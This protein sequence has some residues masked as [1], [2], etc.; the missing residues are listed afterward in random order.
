MWYKAY[1]WEDN[2]FSIKPN[3]NLIGLEKEKEQ[4]THFLTSGSVCL[5]TGNTGTGKTS[6]LKL[7][8]SELKKERVVYINAEELDEF[9]DLHK[10]L[11]SQRSLLDKVLFRPPRNVLLLLD[12]GHASDSKLKDHIKTLYDHGVLKGVVM[13]QTKPPFDYS[14]GFRHRIGNRI[15]RMSK[16]TDQQARELIELRTEGKHPFHPDAMDALAR[17]ADY[18]PRKLLELC[19]LVSMHLADKVKGGELKE[20]GAEHATEVVQRVKDNFFEE[21]P[22]RLTEPELDSGVLDLGAVDSMA[23][24]PMQNRVLKILAEG[25]RS[26]GQLAQILNTSEGSVGKQLS[27]LM[28]RRVVK[29][30]NHRRPKIYGLAEDF[31]DD[32]AS[33]GPDEPSD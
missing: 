1:Q 29:V 21:E 33:L 9:F 25:H 28:E 12:E 22:Y 24:S 26:A 8:R 13:A 6:L 3:T 7:L 17:H 20:I 27:L 19:E 5:L 4:V 16:L 23:F 31:K 15:V 14:E 32:L 10:H 2:P 11:R 18:N 30:V